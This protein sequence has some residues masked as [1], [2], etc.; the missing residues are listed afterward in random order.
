MQIL[1]AS[2]TPL[3]AFKTTRLGDLLV[4]G[5]IITAEQ[6]EKALN[7]QRSKGWRLGV[8]LI[9]LCYLTEDILHSDLTSQFG[10]LLVD[11]STC[12]VEREVV[13]LLTRECVV[14]FPVVPLLRSGHV[15]TVAVN[16]PTAVS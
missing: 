5:G 15:P 10:V 2:P 14:C 16:A 7:Y 13:T 11:L 12:D 1:D 9:K 6:L 3:G 4:A 8:C